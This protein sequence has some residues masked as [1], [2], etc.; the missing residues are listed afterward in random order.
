M[1][2]EDGGDAVLEYAL[3][4]AFF[5]LAAVIAIHG[6]GLELG[7]VFQKAAAALN[8]IFAGGAWARA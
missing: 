5:G 8:T 1:H 7:T 6:S 3:L 4:L 2:L